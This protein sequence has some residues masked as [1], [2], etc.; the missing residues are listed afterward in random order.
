[1]AT[2]NI[3]PAETPKDPLWK[4]IT[5]HVNPDSEIRLGLIGVPCNHSLSPGRCDLAP[6]AIRLAFGRISGHSDPSKWPS[7]YVDFGDLKGSKPEELLAQV[8][9][10]KTAME[11]VDLLIG[12]GGDNGATRPML[13]AHRATQSSWEK[14]GL[15]TI[16]PHLDNRSLEPGIHNGNVIAAL[17]QDGLSAE[18]IFQIGRR[19]F[20]N[21]PV[22]VSRLE[23]TGPAVLDHSVVFERGYA[24]VLEFALEALSNTCDSVHVDIDM[25]TLDNAFAPACPGARPGGITPTV[26]FEISTVIG[27]HPVVTSVDFVEID[28]DRDVGQRTSLCAAMAIAHLCAA[29]ASRKKQD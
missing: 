4:K 5:E 7:E 20:M 25:D 6:E 8:G 1:M 13:H 17:M 10:L 26:L 21:D 23:S 16:D 15:V 14:I 27:A 12:L 24:N 9:E 22:Y 19:E 3:D 28:P 11:R 2:G 18:N 29:A